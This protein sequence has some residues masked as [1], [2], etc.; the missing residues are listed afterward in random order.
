VIGL[1]TGQDGTLAQ[2]EQRQYVKPVELHPRL[3]ER[4]ADTAMYYLHPTPGN[5]ILCTKA[6]FKQALLAVLQEA[7]EIGF[8]AGQK[9][10]YLEFTRPG[11]PTRPV[12]MDIRLD[13]P[14]DLARHHIRFKLVVL[15]SLVDAGYRRLGDLRWVPNRELMALH[16]IGFKTARQILAIVRRFER[17]AGSPT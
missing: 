10:H 6:A 8:L 4:L 11:S 9:E 5:K 13:D 15:K 1:R 12:W 17:N 7:H 3:A 14:E 2:Q 16:Y